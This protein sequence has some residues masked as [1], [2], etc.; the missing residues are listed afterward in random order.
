M[1][2]NYNDNTV[3]KMKKILGIAP[4]VLGQTA[5]EGCIVMI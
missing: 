5:Y 3:N 1:F 4:N 2:T